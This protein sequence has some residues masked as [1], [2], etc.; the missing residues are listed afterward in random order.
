MKKREENISC[1][2]NFNSRQACKRCVYKLSC[3]FYTRT[4]PGINGRLG[5]VSFDNTVEEW[6]VDPDSHIPGEEEELPPQFR[7]EMISA[8]GQM[9]KWLMSLDGYTLGLVAEMISPTGTD[10]GGV[11]MAYLAKLRG[12][13]RQ[14]IHEK[15]VDSVLRFPELSALF[16]TALRRMGSLKCKFESCVRNKKSR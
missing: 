9:L 8:L 11:S 13:T 4:T 6:Y 7:D 5:M 10:P 16:Q 1:Y 3:E 2:G 15:M 14:S 12:C